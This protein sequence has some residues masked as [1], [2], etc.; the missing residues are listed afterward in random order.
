MITDLKVEEAL[1]VIAKNADL[2][3]Q[4]RGQKSMLEHKVKITR[5]QKFLMVDG[6]V[7][8]RE[9]MALASP[10]YQEVVEELKDCIT[11][12]ETLLTKFKA[13]ELVIDVWRTM[14]ANKRR[15]HI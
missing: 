12:L 9:A 11:E 13:A 7:A 15:G 3:G 2:I 10:E 6:A 4:L 1:G 14:N 5:S 8:A